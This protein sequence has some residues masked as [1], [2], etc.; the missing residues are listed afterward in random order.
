MVIYVVGRLLLIYAII[1]FFAVRP[2]IARW[3]IGKLVRE[4][5]TNLSGTVLFNKTK[6]SSGSS[7]SSSSSGSKTCVTYQD[8]DTPP[9][10]MHWKVPMA[11]I[12]GL[13]VAGV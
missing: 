10:Q 6:K 5:Q 8:T 13:A 2:Q 7:G 12:S 9:I 1:G 3:T 4:K 11:S